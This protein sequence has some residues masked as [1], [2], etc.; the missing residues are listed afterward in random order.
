MGMVAPN[1]PSHAGARQETAGAR[2]AKRALAKR[3]LV[4]ALP[5]CPSLR[6]VL[7]QPGQVEG[8]CWQRCHG[9]LGQSVVLLW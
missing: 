4:H 1:L 8:P 2:A 5:P 7:G 3:Q 9:A 6:A